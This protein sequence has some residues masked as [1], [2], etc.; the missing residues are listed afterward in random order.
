V[1]VSRDAVVG[2]VGFAV[3]L[4]VG[5]LCSGAIVEFPV[6]REQKENVSVKL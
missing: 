5:T 3:G 4:R 6:I 1:I 2:S